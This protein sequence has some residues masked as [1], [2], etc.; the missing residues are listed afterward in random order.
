MIVVHLKKR[1]KEKIERGHLWIYADELK[2]VNADEDVGV[3]NVF[4]DD[5]FLGRGF[6]NGK[7]NNSLKIFTRRYEE[8]NEKFFVKRFEFALN[9]RQ[10]LPLFRREFNAEGDF[11]PGLIVDRFSDALVVQIRALSLES[12]KD[13]IV[14]ALVKVYNPKSIYERSDFESLP[15]EGLLREKGLLY[16]SMPS[17]KT[18][19]ENGLKFKVNMVKGQKTGFFYDQRDSRT[20]VKKIASRG[21]GLDLFTYTGG[22]AISMAVSGM[23]VDA[24]DISEE[25]LEIAGENAKLNGVNVN[26]MKR[27][28]FDL[29]G[30][31]MYDLIVADP[32]SLVKKSSQRSKARDL[33]LKLMDQIFDHLKENGIVGICSCAYNIDRDMLT[34]VV[35]KSATNKKR[36]I[37]AVGWTELPIDHP[38]LLS[39]PETNYL[40][41]LW[42]EALSSMIYFSMG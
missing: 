23:L 16:G 13:K 38:H 35:V 12:L 17:E 34:K 14:K 24:V 22:F 2:D 10:N 20:F 5:E 32:P 33:L 37:R 36:M 9:R 27:D 40:K 39:M 30:L 1:G 21:K 6:Y 18:L 29:K 8:I 15:E 31:G 25:D 3:A 41:C 26:F 19:E 28:A 4:F 42:I 11:L 7:A